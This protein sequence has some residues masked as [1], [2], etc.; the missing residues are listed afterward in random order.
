VAGESGEEDHVVALRLVLSV[1]IP[2]P[3]LEA[4]LM[5][6]ELVDGG[7]RFPSVEEWLFCCGPDARGS[8]HGVAL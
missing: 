3:L 1:Q 2:V 4:R 8:R 7:H 6:V 5:L